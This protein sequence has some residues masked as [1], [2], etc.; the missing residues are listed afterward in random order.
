M[1]DHLIHDDYTIAWITVLPIET[2]AA[3]GM[4]DK[5]HQGQFESVRGDDY[6]YTGG[7]IQEEYPCGLTTPQQ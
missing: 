4:L 1:A 3:L 7:E 2:E 5:Q 6:I